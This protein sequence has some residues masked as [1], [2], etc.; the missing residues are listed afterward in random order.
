M[1]FGEIISSAMGSNL[2]TQ[3]SAKWRIKIKKMLNN[4]K[5]IL[6]LFAI[7]LLI[8]L[9]SC[10]NDLYEDNITEKK[11]AVV[12]NISLKDLPKQENNKLFEKVNQIRF[13]KE[14]TQ[15]KKNHDSING[16]YFDDQNGKLIEY[17]DGY[18]SYTFQVY[19]N[20]GDDK[21]Q[22]ILFSKKRNGEFDAYLVKYSFTEKE[23]NTFTKKQLEKQKVEFIKISA[24]AILQKQQIVCIDYMSWTSYPI[25]QGD[26]TGNYGY[27]GHWVLTKSVCQNIDYTESGSIGST[28]WGTG[29][30]NTGSGSTG[31]NNGSGISTTPVV[32]QGTTFINSLP[33]LTKE[34]VLGL[35]AEAQQLIFSYLA[36]HN[37]DSP[38][39]TI[40]KN[41][42]INM[43][44]YWFEEQSL[45]T[46]TNV[47]KYL[48]QNGF[49][50]QSVTFINQCI[51]RISQN[52]T[53]YTSITPF[54][55]E[56]QI[57]DTNLDPC[58]KGVME[59]LKNTTNTDIAN[60]L[61]KLG[62][63]SLYTVNIV[64][65][66]ATTY[67]EAQKISKYNY[68]IRVDRDR[69]TDGTK[70]FKA[71]ALIH[72]VIH[73]YFLSILDDYNTTPST[74]LPSFP[75][76]FE[77]YVKKAHPT[78][79]DKQD[80]QHLAMANKYVDAMASALQEY[81]ANYLIDYQVYKDLAWGGLSGTPIFNETYPLG[82]AENTRIL[83][84]YRA[85]SSGHAVEQ[86]TSNQQT[87]VGK[88][89]N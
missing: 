87:P 16:F 29:S 51:T 78:S 77:V 3:H 10:T 27:T 21:I 56:K 68:E 85:E 7:C 64:M 4:Q 31:N 57:I 70:L 69:H 52:P 49:S 60:V 22:N 15:G 61:A 41:A 44:L 84:R 32:T 42:L 12:K 6:K 46:H 74:A 30:F 43:K 38:T 72:E 63:N 28:G 88:P 48:F 80:A 14:N 18:K 24:K 66:P 9:N 81:D 20:K 17:G 67:A 76:L 37:F 59:Q 8:G 79:T 47:F 25:D 40:V 39:Q 11:E 71:T 89:C 45:E 54:L 13:K 58:P 83:N 34:G 23:L 5:T 35:T 33:S 2:S 62:A 50:S 26:L 86:G 1:C 55:I 65:K 36:N 19:N 75:E 53:V 73:A 82:S